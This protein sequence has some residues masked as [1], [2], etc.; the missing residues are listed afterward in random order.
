MVNKLY[1]VQ[2]KDGKIPST[3]FHS[4]SDAIKAHGVSNIVKIDEVSTKKPNI[5]SITKSNDLILVLSSRSNDDLELSLKCGY[6]VTYNCPSYKKTFPGMKYLEVSENQVLEGEIL[7][8]EKFDLKQHY[9]WASIIP[10]HQ[11]KIWKWSIYHS[12]SIIISRTEAENKYG[13]I[14]GV[15]G[16]IGYIDLSKSKK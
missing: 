2:L 14:P 8:L 10:R 12:K 11:E 13:K 7:K 6:A 16:G 15:Q 4:I 3:L 9:D 5:S 1:K